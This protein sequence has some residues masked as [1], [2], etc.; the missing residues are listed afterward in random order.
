MAQF[1]VDCVAIDLHFIVELNTARE[2]EADELSI[3]LILIAILSELKRSCFK[4]NSLF[5]L[6][7]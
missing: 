4:T 6:S 2:R 3:R 5:S 1:E 7:I